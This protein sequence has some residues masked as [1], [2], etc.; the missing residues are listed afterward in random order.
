M[1]NKN[2][3]LIKLLKEIN[4][5]YNANNLSKVIGISSMGALKILKTLEKE[6]LAVSEKFG[7]ASFYKINFDNNYAL[8][9]LELSLK[10][11]IETSASYTKRWINELRKITG[12]EIIVLFGS[13]LNNGEKAED[14]DVLFVLKHENFRKLRL[15][16]EDLNNL[17]DKKI[18]SIYQ[19][20]EDFKKNLI[21]KDKIVLDAIKGIF[22]HGQRSFLE[23][24]KELK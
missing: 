23:I 21:K 6:G 20:E 7:R 11:E 8:D 5:N 18:H 4:I 12:A 24:L 16:I 13:V 14:I 9:F 17:N 1:N 2:K 3:I 10:T 15:E 22:I 19:T